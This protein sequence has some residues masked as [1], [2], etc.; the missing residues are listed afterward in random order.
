MILQKPV[1]SI[2]IKEHYGL[3]DI[4]NFC[5]Q[6]SVDSL[7]SWMTSFYTNSELKN[8]LISKG[9]EYIN[10]Y[11]SNQGKACKSVLKFLEEF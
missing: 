11:L 3:P 10:F 8:D 9:N 1:V 2:R 4:F 7:D 6:F 5:P